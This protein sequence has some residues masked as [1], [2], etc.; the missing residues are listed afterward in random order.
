MKCKIIRGEI[1]TMSER[2]YIIETKRYID[3]KGNTTF[4]S[5]TTS[6]KVVEVKHEDQ[7]LVFFP[8]EGDNA[9]KKHYIPFANIHIVRE[10]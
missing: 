2:K 4:D 5:W 9:G 1:I 7:Y 10:L 8:L 6:A 3:D